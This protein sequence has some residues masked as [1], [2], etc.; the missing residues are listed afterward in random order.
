MDR[1]FDNGLLL[2][3]SRDEKDKTFTRIAWKFLLSQTMY[4]L[5]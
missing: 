2:T 4:I 5:H 1:K 3:L